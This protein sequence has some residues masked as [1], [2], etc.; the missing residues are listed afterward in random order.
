MVYP[1]DQ[2]IAQNRNK[3]NTATSTSMTDNSNLMKFHLI[4]M[5][6]KN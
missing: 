5:G 2:T 3:D 4:F 6:L 1:Y